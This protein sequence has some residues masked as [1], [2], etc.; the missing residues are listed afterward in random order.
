MGIFLSFLL[1]LAVSSL[2]F[3]TSVS[4]LIALNG[5]TALIFLGV[6]IVFGI[7][8]FDDFRRLGSTIK[9]LF[10][11]LGAT[12]AFLGGLRIGHFEFLSLSLQFGILSYFITL[13]WFVLFINV[14]NL[15]DGL[16]GLAGALLSLPV[17][18]WL[19]LQFSRRIS[20][21]GPDRIL[22]SAFNEAG[23]V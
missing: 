23:Q 6:L 1:T 5:Q 9:F 21:Y 14:V 18:S 20:Y 7:G 13:F 16:D 17:A 4:D 10:Q 2:L 12:L 8:L 11:I 15:I 22:I 3:K 19:F